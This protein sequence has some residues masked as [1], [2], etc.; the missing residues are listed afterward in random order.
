MEYVIKVSQKGTKA[1]PA[2]C[3]Y[4]AKPRPI[5]AT[6][7]GARFELVENATDAYRW[8]SHSALNA[9]VSIRV[10]GNSALA[11]YDIEE[12]PE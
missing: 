12:L 11:S 2:A 8:K 10:K 4:V 9:W 7:T 1:I 5:A 3:G 6:K